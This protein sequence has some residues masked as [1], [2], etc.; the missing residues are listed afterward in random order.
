M[1]DVIT[2]LLPH[3]AGDATIA[4]RATMRPVITSV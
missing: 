3:S 4:N 1:M 2:P